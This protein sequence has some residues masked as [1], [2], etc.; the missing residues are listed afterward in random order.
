MWNI[1]TYRAC[2]LSDPD[3][4]VAIIPILAAD[5]AD[6]RHSFSSVQTAK[7]LSG[8]V[9]EMNVYTFSQNCT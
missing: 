3:M 6:T 8:G 1:L 4:E 7:G 5:E 9:E 2:V